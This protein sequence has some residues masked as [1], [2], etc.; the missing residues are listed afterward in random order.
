M[1]ISVRNGYFLLNGFERGR[2]FSMVHG[3]DHLLHEILLVR[4]SRQ[5]LSD[6]LNGGSFFRWG[7][8]GINQL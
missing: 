2:S 8:H 1:L 4:H 6:L 7:Q 3:L 5:F